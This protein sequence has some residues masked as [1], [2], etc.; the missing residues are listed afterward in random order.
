MEPQHAPE[1]FST[2]V[3]PGCHGSI[4]LSRSGFSC[5]NCNRRYSWINGA[6]CLLPS[7]VE[8]AV[9]V[10]QPRPSWQ[11]RYIATLYSRANKSPAARQGVAQVLEMLRPGE[12]GLNA[13]SSSTRIHPQTVNLD[14]CSSAGVDVIGTI[15]DLPFRDGSMR[16]VISQE[17]FEHVPDPNRAA[18][19]VFRILAPG[20][21]FYI[22]TPFILGIHGA[23]HDY[24]RFTRYG[25]RL[26]L[27]RAGFEV[28]EI[29]PTLG[30][31]TALYQVAVEYSASIA[32]ALWKKLYLPVK[33]AAALLA[34]P[35][36]LADF[37]T[38]KDSPF[39]RVPGGYYA[40]ARKP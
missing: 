31:G 17:V 28:E 13:G 14:I 10:D 34:V 35:L 33:G 5:A 30:S 22:Q 29:Q 20:G 12:W 21:K 24:W 7:G 15:E 19:E 27:A 25:L 26:L 32:A 16:C 2:L 36:R 8:G 9:V 1:W 4:D 11:A 23:P 37:V 40:I 3:C 6:P 38:L 39:N 18:R